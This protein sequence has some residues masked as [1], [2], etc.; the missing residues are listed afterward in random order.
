MTHYC[1]NSGC[2]LTPWRRGWC[3]QHWKEAAGFVF[4]SARG[5]FIKADHGVTRKPL[6]KHP[7]MA[8]GRRNSTRAARAPDCSLAAAAE[9]R[10]AWRDDRTPAPRNSGFPVGLPEFGTLSAP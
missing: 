4:D 3:Y 2:R 7:S 10:G 6:G 9:D 1:K 8:A 5:M